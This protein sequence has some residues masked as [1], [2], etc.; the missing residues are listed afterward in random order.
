MMA[1]IIIQ[2]ILALCFFPLS[3]VSFAYN[4]THLNSPL[5]IVNINLPQTLPVISA[6]LFIINSNIAILSKQHNKITLTLQNVGPYVTKFTASPDK[7]ASLSPT[8]DIIR[9]WI[10]GQTFTPS[11]PSSA[12]AGIPLNRN[13]NYINYDLE[14]SNPVYDMKHATLTFNV[15]WTSKLPIPTTNV[16][17]TNVSLVVDDGLQIALNETTNPL[18]ASLLATISKHIPNQWQFA[19]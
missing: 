2:F 7:K 14:L 10:H 18:T 13:K 6:S 19:S 11:T 1:K 5:P 17:L 9:D 15:I 4:L 16:T 12:L 3:S 8:E